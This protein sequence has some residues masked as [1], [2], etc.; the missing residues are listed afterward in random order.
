[1]RSDSD[2]GNNG[3]ASFLK[4]A[5]EEGICVEYSEVYYRTQPHSKLKRVV[6]VI[7]R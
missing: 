4:G 3:M 5:E 2:Y 6:E 1:M 7:R